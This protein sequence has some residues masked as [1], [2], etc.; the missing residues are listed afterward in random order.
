MSID[1][2]ISDL[3]RAGQLHAI[4][5]TMPGD[6]LRREM[7]VSAEV[8]GH[9]D[10]P[11][12]A[13]AWRTRCSR[14]RANLESFVLGDVISACTVPFSAG[15]AYLGL[16]SPPTAGYWD[17]RSRD[18][19]PSLRILGGFARYD[20]FVGLIPAVRCDPSEYLDRG[21]L[22]D[23]FSPEWRSAILETKAEWKRLFLAYP[24]ISG[25]DLNDLFSK[26]YD[27]V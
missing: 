19:K 5:P 11:W 18:P 6:P 12:P 1:A 9:L 17:I 15:K 7:L 13:S 8:R 26:P 21:P 27:P 24:P 3:V 2:L 23:K 20:T 22:G 16:L 10:G 25:T 14:L 4:E